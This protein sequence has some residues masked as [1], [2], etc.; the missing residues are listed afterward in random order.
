MSCI[1]STLFCDS[2]V[3][4]GFPGEYGVDEEGCYIPYIYMF[5]S[6]FGGIFVTASLIYIFVKW[7]TKVP[8]EYQ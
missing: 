8:K 7:V 4:C 2:K 6:I 3:D 5:V 1:Y